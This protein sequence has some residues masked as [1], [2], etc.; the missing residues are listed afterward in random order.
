MVV[1]WWCV[2]VVAVFE[3]RVECDVRFGD[4]KDG[5]V[6]VFGGSGGNV[7]A[8]FALLKQPRNWVGGG[9]NLSDGPCRDH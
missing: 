4:E 7:I 8:G 9:L 2:F 6:V 1:W 3:T 5:G